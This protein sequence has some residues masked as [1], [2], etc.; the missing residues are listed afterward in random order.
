MFQLYKNVAERGRWSEDLMQAHAMY[1]DGNIN[2]AL[3]KYAFLAELGYEVAQSNT[4]YILDMEEATVIPDNE[5]YP[6][7]LIYWSRAAL[8]GIS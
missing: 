3:V 8:Q 4:A 1:K 7:A 2:G 6:R 5:T